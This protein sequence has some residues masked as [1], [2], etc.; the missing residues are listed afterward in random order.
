MQE[1]G[2]P[3]EPDPAPITFERNPDDYLHWDLTFDPPIAYLSMNVD[4][5]GATLG[6]YELKLNS[7]DI[8][9][10]IELASAVRRIRLEHPEVR[11]VVLM[12]AI[13]GTFC[14]GANIRMLAA[15]SHAHKVNF[16]KFTNETR[17]EIEEASARSGLRFLAAINGACS[18]GGYELAM[19]CDHLLLVDDSAS[20][21]SLPELP[22]L[23]VLPGTGGLTRLTDKR[24]VRRDRA[25]MFA[26]KPEGVRGREAVEWGLVDELAPIS[27]FDESVRQRALALAA[28]SDRDADAEPIMV[29]EMDPTIDGDT[30]RYRN[31]TAEHDRPN[32]SIDVTV[33]SD[34]RP[35]WPLR[36]ALELD[37]LLCHLRFNEPSVATIVLHARG[38]IDDVLAHDDQLANPANHAA[39]ET[40]LLWARV[41]SRLDLTARSLIAT[42]EPGSCFAGILAELSLAADRT[43]M[44]EGTFEDDADHLPAAE[45]LLTPVNTGPMPMANG[46]TRLR[47]RLWGDDTAHGEALD[48]VGQRLDAEAAESL[49]LV[50]S[51]PDDID[52]HDEIRLAIEE[53]ATFS[54]DALTGMEANH[55]FCGP[56][57][58]AT[59]IFGRLSA[60]Q[61]WIFI[62]P[63]ASGPD[64]AL[65][66]FGTGTRAEF[67]LERT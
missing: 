63:N 47:S 34:A 38:S 23:G 27:D 43:Y 66:R 59:K 5:G 6:D 44:L 46:I 14:A 36:T 10:D 45:V 26:T 21:V 53:R 64:G 8:G 41:L 52:W 30:H 7:Y 17:L 61:N 55:R 42:I 16:C 67:D 37:D 32:R 9:V 62:R 12:S 33:H 50:S 24:H 18:G 39:R 31:V 40:S 49:G 1:P 29:P 25:D 65:R 35:D 58:M 54:P 13:Q 15:S 20:A 51:A 22:L 2:T 4:P 56:E 19:A 60:W 48:A 57:T 11:C 28:T 3:T